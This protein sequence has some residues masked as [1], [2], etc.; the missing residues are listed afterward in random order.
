[1]PSLAQQL[2]ELDSAAPQ[3]FDVDDGF[4]QPQQVDHGR[5]HYLDV[6]PSS[7]RKLAANEL[8]PKYDARKIS[9]HEL[10]VD[11]DDAISD[12]DPSDTHSHVS[13]ERPEPSG[14]ELEDANSGD[15]SG[16]DSGDDS[17]PQTPADEPI[18]HDQD[19]TSSTL[20]IARRADIAKGKA[21]VRQRQVWDALIDTRIRLQKAIQ[22]TRQHSSDSEQA[23]SSIQKQ[24][25]PVFTNGAPPKPAAAAAA[26]TAATAR[27]F[28]AAFD[29]SSALF[30]VQDTLFSRAT[31]SAAPP[32]KKR[33]LDVSF[34]SADALEETRLRTAELAELDAAYHPHLIQAVSPGFV[35]SANANAFSKN[36]RT[37]AADQRDLL[38]L[39]DDLLA[40]RAETDGHDWDDMSFYQSLLRD[41]IET[42]GGG[43]AGGGGAEPWQLNKTKRAA[44]KNLKQTVDTK[45]SKGRKLRYTVHDK[46]QHFMVPIRAGAWHEEQI[47]ELFAS[48]LGRGFEDGGAPR[49]KEDVE[50][51]TDVQMDD[52]FRLFG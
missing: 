1:M 34:A 31:S 22:Y 11:G 49:P 4:E 8:D 47:D 15:N 12:D 30:A 10:D 18:H 46:I 45:A 48:L 23:I 9:R 17:V 14:S 51:R 3:E 13:A 38:E 42:R 29:L 6:G 28:E 41:I 26:A 44:S 2:A 50:E 20:H 24:T 5:D 52:G 7:L 16:D 40:K 35:A 21:V 25:S 27:F 43:S 37:A 39:I 33:R 32:R 36:K 19:N